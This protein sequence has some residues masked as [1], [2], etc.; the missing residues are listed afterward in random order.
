MNTIQMTFRIISPPPQGALM[1]M[2]CSVLQ[3][4]QVIQALTEH[5]NHVPDS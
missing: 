4:F 5:Q 3:V 2:D 1:E